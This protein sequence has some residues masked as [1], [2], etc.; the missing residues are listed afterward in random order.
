MGGLDRSSG[1]GGGEKYLDVGG[2]FEVGL[3]GFFN[4]LDKWCV[5]EG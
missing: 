1:R 3:V 2:I 4:G 5:M